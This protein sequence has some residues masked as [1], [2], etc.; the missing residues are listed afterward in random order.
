MRRAVAEGGVATI[1]VEVDV[2]V[3]SDFQPGFFQ[4]D[5]GT[6]AEQQLCFER[7]PARL[8]L[9]VVVGFAGPAKAGQR[10]R[11]VN[12]GM[13]SRAGVLAAPVGVNNQARRGLA[14]RQDLF[15]G[16]QHEFGGHVGGQVPPDDPA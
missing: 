5:K 12:A 1:E 9:R 11:L 13:A 2:E 6:A 7:T 4:A 15:Q 8:G 3:V 14:Q 16:Q 10:P